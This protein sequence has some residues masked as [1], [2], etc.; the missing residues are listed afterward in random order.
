[1]FDKIKKLFSDEPEGFQGKGHR[2]GSA[3]A[4]PSSGQ[5]A[6]QQGPSQ[7]A[8]SRANPPTRAGTGNS[9]ILK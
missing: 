9:E 2:L 5:P 1:M 4:P 7:A 8:G 6:R 3:A